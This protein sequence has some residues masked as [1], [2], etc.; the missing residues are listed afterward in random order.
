M[1]MTIL[2]MMLLGADPQPAPGTHAYDA[3]LEVSFAIEAC[4]GTKEEQQSKELRALLLGYWS[5]VAD[6]LSVAKKTVGSD[7]VLFFG[8]VGG[9][10]SAQKKP[11]AKVVARLT[12]AMKEVVAE[13]FA[14]GGR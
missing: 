3:Q 14:K 6:T 4:G 5:G 11:T 9:K 13:L 12:G 8:A 10:C 7:D 2:A 1:M